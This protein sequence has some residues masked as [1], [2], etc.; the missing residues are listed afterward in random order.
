MSIFA[1]FIYNHLYLF[2][3]HYLVHYDYSSDYMEKQDLET[4]ICGYHNNIWY[5]VKSVILME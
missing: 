4:S 5:S 1:Y 2:L 3:Y